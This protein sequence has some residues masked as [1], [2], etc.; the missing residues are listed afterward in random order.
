[1]TLLSLGEIKG[2]TDE[3]LS[4]RKPLI[5]KSLE[6]HLEIFRSTDGAVELIDE[7]SNQK[8][9]RNAIAYDLQEKL[10][11]ESGRPICSNCHWVPNPG[12]TNCCIDPSLEV[13]EPID[14]YPD[15][16]TRQDWDDAFGSGVNTPNLDDPHLELDSDAYVMTSV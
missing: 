2:L 9:I 7:W 16:A 6:R 4:Q 14:E 5:V 1:M 8:G 3:Q 11:E 10:A 15:D 13:I 12:Q